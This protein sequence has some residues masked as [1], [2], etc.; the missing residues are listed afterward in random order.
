MPSSHSSLLIVPG[1][2]AACMYCRWGWQGGPNSFIVYIE[3]LESTNGTYLNN[4]RLKSGKTVLAHND[5]IMLTSRD[6]GSNDP[7]TYKWVRSD[8]SGVNKAGDSPCFES[9]LL[10]ST[11]F[12]SAAPGPKRSRIDQD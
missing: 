8:I 4:R 3:D 11:L 2:D 10:I 5:E 1:I 9:F 12:L 6:K 7:P